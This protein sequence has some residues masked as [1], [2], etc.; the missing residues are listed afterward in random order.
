MSKHTPGPWITVANAIYAEAEYLPAP[1]TDQDGN[2]HPDHMGG[3]IA[4]VYER[5][6]SAET[7]GGNTRLIAAAPD[8]LAALAALYDALDDAEI[9]L[10]E[11]DCETGLYERQMDDARAAI[12]K[13]RG[14]Q[15]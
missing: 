15:S 3:L 7:G 11:A 12:A 5:Y 8:L 13:A 4:L 10:D 1:F 6:G 9:R 2:E 14:E